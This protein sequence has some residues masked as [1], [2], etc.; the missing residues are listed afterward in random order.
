M[1]Y[2]DLVLR[3]LLTLSKHRGKLSLNLSCQLPYGF[4]MDRERCH[5]GAHIYT[6]QSEY[7]KLALLYRDPS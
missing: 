7:V 2:R 6:I 3:G 1:H 5:G 4:T